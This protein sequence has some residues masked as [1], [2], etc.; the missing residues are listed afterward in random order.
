MSILIG[1]ATIENECKVLIVKISNLLLLRKA[2]YSFLLLLQYS[3]AWMYHHLFT[4]PAVE[5]YLSCFQ[6]GDILT[7]VTMN[8]CV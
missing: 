1:Y 6:L 8:I 7:N 3:T 2:V 5:E 4:Y